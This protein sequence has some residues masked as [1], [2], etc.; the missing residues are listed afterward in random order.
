MN[1]ISKNTN[2]ESSLNK[3]VIDNFL[4]VKFVYLI[5]S[6]FIIAFCFL[7]VIF[8]NNENTFNNAYI[9]IQKDLFYYLNSKLSVFPNLQYNLTQL[10]DVIILF[11]FVAIFIL[12]APKLWEAIV[13]SSVL[14]LIVSALL[15]KIFSIPR[16]AAVF[17]N[18]SFTIIGRT[19][20][21]STSLPSGHSMT[22]FVVIT[23]L[24]Y[25]FMPKKTGQKIIWFLFMLTLG[26]TITFCRVGVGAHYPLDVLI[27]SLIGYIIA[28]IGIKLNEK[29]NWLSK[30]KVPKEGIVLVIILLIWIGLIIK[31]IINKNLFIAYLSIIPVILTII[32]LLKK[33]VQNKN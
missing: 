4:K 10:G 3:S 2:N 12:Y 22:T 9:N 24:L 7:L 26:F 17:D 33:Y 16:P 21:G 25:A 1:K 23:L 32:L 18:E 30:L 19:L 8:L 11:P 27:G 29:L 5:P 28:I 14:S 15:K 6:F 13:T 20:R 31:I